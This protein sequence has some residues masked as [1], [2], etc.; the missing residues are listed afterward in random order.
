MDVRTLNSIVPG[1][2]PEAIQALSTDANAV[3]LIKAYL[4]IP[5]ESVKKKLRR[6]A[7]EIAAPVKRGT[8]AG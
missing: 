8:K 7:E 5:D 6:L 1:L 4:A 3:A 2:T